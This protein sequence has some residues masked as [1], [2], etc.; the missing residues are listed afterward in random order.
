MQHDCPIW[1]LGQTQGPSNAVRK[2]SFAELAD[3]I[4]LGRR[5]RLVFEA[6]GVNEMAEFSSVEEF[7]S[8]T[9]KSCESVKRLQ[10]GILPSRTN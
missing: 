8:M 3:G 5:C 9:N 6:L 10:V 2:D 1:L 4:L 7:D